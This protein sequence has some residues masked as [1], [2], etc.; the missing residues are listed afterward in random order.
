[1]QVGGVDVRRGRPRPAL[2]GHR[3]RAAASVPVH[4]HRRIEP[5]VRPRGGDRRGALARAR[6]RAGPRLRRGDGGAA[7][8]RGSRRA[9]P[10]SRAASASASPSPGRSCTSPTSSSSTTRSRRSTS[11][12]T[13]GCARRCGV[14][15]PDVTK[16]VVAQRVSTITDADRIV[17]LD[18]GQMVGVGTHEE[19]LRDQRD[20]PRDRRVAAGGG[21]MSAPDLPDR[22]RAP[23]ARARRAGAPELRRLG[24]RRARQG[25]ELR[26]ELRPPHRPAEAAR[27]RVHLRLD[28]RL[29]R[30]RARG[31]R[32]E[33]AR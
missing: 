22:G 3:P 18:D 6:D 1:M 4:R 10:T 8:A 16:I 30:R 17:V 13:R 21:G 2:E 9:A 24:Q 27:L 28:P 11:P 14:S 32:P 25:H 5:A 29:D 19:L 20:L 12:P 31:D 7:R 33:D 23:R 26:Q 15:C